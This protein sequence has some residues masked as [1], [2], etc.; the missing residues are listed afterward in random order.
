MTLVIAHRGNS[1]AAPE[2]TFASF[3]S[4]IEHGATL[5]ECDVQMTGDGHIVVIHDSTLD[6]TSDRTGDVRTMTLA[7]VKAADVSCPKQFGTRFSLQRAATLGELL[8][9]LKGRAR[10][11]LEIKK[12]SSHA[13]SDAFERRIAAEIVR[14]GVR[15]SPDM[16]TDIAVISF[17]TLALERMAAIL[18]DAPRGHLFYRDPEETLFA[19]A[20]AAKASFVMPEKGHLSPGLLEHARQKGLG[21]AT[22]VCD[23]PEEFRKLST[24]GLLGIGTN[25]PVEM[26]QAVG[27]LSD[28]AVSHP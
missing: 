17:S 1:S 3:D 16:D 21:V 8:A 9:F 7:E 5:V 12:E 22:W 2:N 18:P 25:R 13:D 19:S 6:R 23:D 24:L 10:L 14:S 4:A 11:M 27:G 28:T 20:L 26:A 15:T